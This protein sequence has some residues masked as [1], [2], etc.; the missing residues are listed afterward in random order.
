MSLLIDD[1]IY[2]RVSRLDIPF[3]RYG[4]DPYGISREHLGFFFT[5]LG[6]FYRNY[7]NVT[8]VG[9]E[10]IPKHDGA[11]IIGNHSGGIPVDAGMVLTSLVLDLDP[12]RLGHAMV[13]KFANK[14]P[15]LSQYYSRFGQFTGIP[16]HAK[17][18]L[19]EGRLVLAFPEGVRGIGKLYS[20]RYQLTRFGTG[21]M[22]IA[23][24]AGVPI[25]PFAFVGGEEAYPVISRLE[26]V[27]KLVGAPFIPVPRHI[28]PIPVPI[29][30]QII[31]GEPMYFEGDGSEADD[32]IFGYVAQVKA[33]VAALIEEG[34]E[35]RRDLFSG[36]IVLDDDDV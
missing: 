8:P 23:L 33:R 2:E 14:L 34:R 25:V 4:L 19:R 18:F 17:R 31:Y 5:S 16:E 26:G 15:F 24:E 20:E 13:E 21:F 36:E 12:P 27:G 9:L 29:S 7:F 6:W 22:R 11:F 32:V 3:N 30:C 10:N 1:E 28:V 35:L